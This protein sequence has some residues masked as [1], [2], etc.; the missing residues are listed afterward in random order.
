MKAAPCMGPKRDHRLSPGLRDP[1]SHVSPVIRQNGGTIINR[2]AVRPK[3]AG[4]VRSHDEKLAG[5]FARLCLARPL[6]FPSPVSRAPDLSVP[7]T[8]SRP[9]ALSFRFASPSLPNE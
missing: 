8:V 4:N 7:Q 2:F 5:L 9:T 6:H 1:L 3:G